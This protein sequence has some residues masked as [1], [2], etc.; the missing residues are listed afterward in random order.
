MHHALCFVKIYDLTKDIHREISKN[1]GNLNNSISE[2]ASNINQVKN[3]AGDM[4][5][6]SETLT[7]IVNQFK[8]KSN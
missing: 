3:Q 1:M 5:N 7:K 8:L 2:I 6:L 4:A